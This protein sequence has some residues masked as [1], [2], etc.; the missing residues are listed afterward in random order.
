M[1]S[2]IDVQFKQKLRME[3]LLC[4]AAMK[5]TPMTK[6][7]IRLDPR[8]ANQGTERG[9]YMVEHSLRQYGA[10]RSVLI[11]KHGTLIAG[12]KTYAKA[13]ELGIPTRIIETDG[14]ELIAVKRTDLDLDTDPEAMGLG[15]ADNR[16]SEVGLAWDA[17]VLTALQEDGAD[18]SAFWFDDEL[19][20]VKEQPQDITPPTDFNSYG[21]DLAT[22]YK[23]P[24][25]AYE[26]SG[27]PK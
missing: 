22:D 13:N 17:D 5:E 20:A 21:D 3:N 27:K 15:I 12:N 24:S 7:D 18:L 6:Q 11:D 1:S 2:N 10:G 9:E 19:L 25:C 16:S 4:F 26:W 14:T 8:N 23:C